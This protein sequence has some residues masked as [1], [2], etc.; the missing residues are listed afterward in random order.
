MAFAVTMTNYCARF[1]L[2]LPL[3]TITEPKPLLVITMQGWTRVGKQ[4]LRFAMTLSCEI[5]VLHVI[6]EDKA[7]NFREL[8]SKFVETPLKRAQLP[9]PELIELKSPYRF[10]VTPIVNHVMTLAKKNPD[11]RVVTV[12][13]ELI[14]SRWYYYFLH[15]Q[16]PSLLKA[17]LLM[18]GNDRIS[19]LNIPW[20]LKSK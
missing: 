1:K 15:S 17:Q 10:V 19:V 3:E 16:R 5:K 7:D 11:R 12:I 18:L 20:Y 2:K 8:W 4:A 14:E 6:E 9:V 13:P